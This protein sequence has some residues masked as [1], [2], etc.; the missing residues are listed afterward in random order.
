M[1]TAVKHSVRDQVKPSFV[2]VDIGWWLFNPVWH[3]MLYTCTHIATVDVKGIVQV[4]S[5][6][7]VGGIIMCFRTRSRHLRSRR[8]VIS[9]H[10][11]KI[12]SIIHQRTSRLLL[13][14][15]RPRHLQSVDMFAACYKFVDIWRESVQ[16]DHSCRSMWHGA[17]AFIM[18]TCIYC[19]IGADCYKWPRGWG[20]PPVPLPSP[21][22][23]LPFLPYLPFLSSFPLSL[24]ASLKS[25]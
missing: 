4:D 17:A 25:S 20:S 5:F 13:C 7:A 12:C 16:I 8:P 24:S 10:S 9:L 3:R 18:S 1:G 6:E 14:H 15:G 11:S 19:P 2:I 22:S 21:S 23:I